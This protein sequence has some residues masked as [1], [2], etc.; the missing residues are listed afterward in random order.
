[1]DEKHS[2]QTP[3]GVSTPNDV[4]SSPAPVDAG[5]TSS[6]TS[7]GA[8]NDHDESGVVDSSA[9][10]TPRVETAGQ[11]GVLTTVLQ[12]SRAEL[13]R[14]LA[15]TQKIHERSWRVIH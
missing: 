12:A 4:Q 2:T 14:L 9:V 10:S 7:D 13:D 15:E 3:R 11:S 1:M 6:K 5:M 8:D